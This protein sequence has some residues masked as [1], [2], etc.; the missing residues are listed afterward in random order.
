MRPFGI[1][2]GRSEWGRF[3]GIFG[4]RSLCGAVSSGFLVDEVRVGEG[5]LDFWCTK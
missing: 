2:V 5:V 3:F 4:V 1:F